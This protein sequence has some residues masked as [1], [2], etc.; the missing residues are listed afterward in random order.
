M[1]Y[2]VRQYS[3]Q[4][5]TENTQDSTPDQNAANLIYDRFVENNTPV[6]FYKEGFKVKEFKPHPRPL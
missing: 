3:Y 4:I 2:Y 1:S 5:E 6:E